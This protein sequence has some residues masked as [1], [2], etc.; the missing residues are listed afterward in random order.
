MPIVNQGY[1][2]QGEQ[3]YPSQQGSSGDIITTGHIYVNNTPKLQ[4]FKIK[5]YGMR[6]NTIHKFKYENV[7]RSLNCIPIY[8]SPPGVTFI[9][10]G[11][12]L[13]TDSEGIIEFNFHFSAIVEKEVDSVNKVTFDL[14]GSKKFEMVAQ[15]SIA[16]KIV[17]FLK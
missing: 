17:P 11:S 8:P 15:N 7:D 16:S 2:N 10:L 6:P 1:T 9:T 5:C 3:D 13:V 14:A 4:V 12:P